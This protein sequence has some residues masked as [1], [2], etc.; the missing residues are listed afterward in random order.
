VTVSFARE[1]HVVRIKVSDTGVG[2]PA[3]QKDQL[4]SRFFRGDNVVKMQV[5]GFG[6]GLY[7][8]KNIIERHGG[9]ITVESKENEGT[10]FTITLPLR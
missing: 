8:V 7:I 10:A 2:I 9:T 6:L 5:Q 4:F 1:V 3:R